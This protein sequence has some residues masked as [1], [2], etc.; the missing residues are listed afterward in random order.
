MNV[1]IITYN[2]P[3]VEI[4]DKWISKMGYNHTMEYE[5]SIKG[6]EVVIHTTTWLI[7]EISVIR[8]HKR[9]HILIVCDSIYIK[10]PE[11]AILKDRKKVHGW[12]DQGRGWLGVT[13]GCRVPFGG[14]DNV[15]KIIVVMVALCEYTR[16][17]QITLHQEV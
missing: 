2:I 13:N 14:D 17:N 10:C 15:L 1:H 7:L 6:N 3:K 9:L 8:N 12:L 4:A 16:S 5:L 11:W